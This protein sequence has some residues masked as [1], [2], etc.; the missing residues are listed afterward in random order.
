[1]IKALKAL[2]ESWWANKFE[3][4]TE[5][6]QI[7]IIRAIES[8]LNTHGWHSISEEPPKDGR[9]IEFCSKNETPSIMHCIPKELVNG[10]K[11]S[12]WMGRFEVYE[13]KEIKSHFSHWRV[14][15]AP[16]DK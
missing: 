7:E 10:G 16:E 2:C 6:G 3:T 1:M 11:F 9:S 14:F 5:H 15:E 4:H 13:D 8:I 12:I